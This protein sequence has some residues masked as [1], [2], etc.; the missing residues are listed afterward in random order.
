MLADNGV[1]TL[2]RIGIVINLY[3]PG[4]VPHDANN[5][6][7][8]LGDAVKHVSKHHPVIT[9]LINSISH[10]SFPPFTQCKGDGDAISNISRYGWVR[11]IQY[12][13]LSART[14]MERSAP[15]LDRVPDQCGDVGAA[16]A[17]DLP[18]AG[19]R[20]DIDLGQI[21]ADHVDADEDQAALFEISPDPR[22]DF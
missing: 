10:W 14:L 11:Q 1:A 22:A 20:G 9:A 8:F 13:V 6:A 16:E 21:I 19:R 7:P 5:S 2:R 12:R 15:L 4:R 17:L 18:D 3:G